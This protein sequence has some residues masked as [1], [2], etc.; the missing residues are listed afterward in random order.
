LTTPG[1]K[2]GAAAK[3]I[4]DKIQGKE[5]GPGE[6]HEEHHGELP[7]AVLDKAKATTRDLEIMISD[8]LRDVALVARTP[9]S[10]KE[11]MEIGVVGVIRRNQSQGTEVAPTEEEVIIIR[12]L[13]KVSIMTI[14]FLNS[15]KGSIILRKEEPANTINEGGRFVDE[16]QYHRTHLTSLTV[17]R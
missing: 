5:E 6:G 2:T 4:E 10:N 15:T 12:H 11:D 14:S 7:E 8:C 3:V 16:M 9:S 13:T 1:R 17:M